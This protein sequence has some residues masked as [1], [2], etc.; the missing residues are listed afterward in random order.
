[1]VSGSAD[2]VTAR[3]ARFLIG[4]FVPVV[5][6]ALSETVSAA[7]GCLRL[8][9]TSVGA[10]GILAAAFV[11]LPVLLR[12]F[13]WYFVTGA[14]AIAGDL[15]GA[16]TVASLMRS[17]SSALGILIAVVLCFALLIIVSTT[18]LLVVS[19]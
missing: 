13:C 5:G 1:M 2:G 19:A 6:G 17:C 8:I 3:A 18:V 11:F 9:K 16:G 12:V 4:S 7:R 14:S 10:Y 15:L